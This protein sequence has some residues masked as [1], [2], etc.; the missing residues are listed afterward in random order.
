MYSSH[1]MNY[2][3]VMQRIA[4]DWNMA[5]N[6]ISDKNRTHRFILAHNSDKMFQHVQRIEKPM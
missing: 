3:N 2:R 6:E 5:V 1:E 4:I